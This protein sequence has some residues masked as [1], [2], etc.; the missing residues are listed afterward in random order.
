KRYREGE[1]ICRRIGDRE[2]LAA[3]LCGLAELLVAGGHGKSAIALLQESERIFREL[4]DH[5]GEEEVL[6][7]RLEQEQLGRAS[8]EASPPNDSFPGHQQITID[9]RSSPHKVWA[10]PPTAPRRASGEE[11]IQSD[12][13]P[14]YRLFSP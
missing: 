14:T 3:I 7:R 12:G 6:K 8:A 10:A 11:G 1:Q 4:G 9:K 5:R 2:H 13:P